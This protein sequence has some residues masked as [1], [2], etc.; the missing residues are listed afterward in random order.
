MRRLIPYFLKFLV[1]ITFAFSSG[2]I[3]AQ[4]TDL[5]I[6]KELG[7]LSK[8]EDNTPEAKTEIIDQD[9]DWSSD[10]NQISLDNSVI[11]Q[12]AETKKV[13][14]IKATCDN[15]R[16]PPTK[17]IILFTATCRFNNC[18]KAKAVR[19][20][21][22]QGARYGTEDGDRCW[23]RLIPRLKA[24]DREDSARGARNK[25]K[26]EAADK[27]YRTAMLS[28]C[29]RHDATL[30]S[31][32]LPTGFYPSW[33]N[34]DKVDIEKASGGL[35]EKLAQIAGGSIASSKAE[36]EIK[37]AQDKANLEAER[38]RKAEAAIAKRHSEIAP[39]C[40]ERV[41]KGH[42]P[43]GC[44]HMCTPPPVTSGASQVCE[45]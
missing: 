30:D 32:Q 36:R 20:C 12:A 27:R 40:N 1:V 10:L 15:V 11:E 24:A 37:A 43:C 25:E 33:D 2:E 42:C 31:G 45:K 28:Y 19:T 7:E 39:Y 5:D 17:P 35:D 26:S 14:E 6:S 29:D 23:E 38:I 41:S 4:S 13:Y 8:P 18:L 3:L 9:Y 16:K 21:E 34:F 44:R 22:E